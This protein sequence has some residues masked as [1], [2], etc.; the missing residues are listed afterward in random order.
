MDTPTLSEVMSDL[1]DH[2]QNQIHTA[3]PGTV[4]AFNIVKN[5]ADIEPGLEV[6]GERLP[7]IP[8]VYVIWPLAYRALSPGEHVLLV[9]CEAEIGAWRARGATGAASHEQRHCLD[10][11]VAIAGLRNVGDVLGYVNGTVVPGN[12][13]HLS[14]HDAAQFSLRATDFAAM[15]TGIPGGFLQELAAWVVLVGAATGVPSAS[16]T[17]AIGTYMTRITSDLLTPKVLVP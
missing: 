1:L 11:A 7:V 3:M 9:F 12:P 5:T 13:V 2:W 16:L 4:R 10:G 8:D 6:A 15:L 14:E 17:A